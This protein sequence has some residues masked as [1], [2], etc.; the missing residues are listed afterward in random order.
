MEWINVKKRLPEKAG[1]FLVFIQWKTTY[2][3]EKPEID[4]EYYTKKRGWENSKEYITHWMPL[5]SPP[6][7]SKPE[8]NKK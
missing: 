1:T 3:K 5:P 8:E 2:W 7:L 6:D 4:I